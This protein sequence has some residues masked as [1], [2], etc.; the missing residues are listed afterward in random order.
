MLT[1]LLKYEFQATA[2]TFAGLYLALLAVAAFVGVL[3][4]FENMGKLSSILSAASLNV[5]GSTFGNNALTTGMLVYGCLVIAMGVLLF[6]TICQ[7]F[8]KN[9][10]G[11]EG[12]LMHTLPVKPAALVASKLLLAVF[13]LVCSIAVLLVSLLVLFAAAT[14]GMQGQL[15]SLSDLL[16]IR[17]NEY[18]L[19]MIPLL[20]MQ[21]IESV[22]CIY[23]AMM[24]GH[25]VVKG[26]VFVSI[27][28]FFL[29]EALQ[30]TVTTWLSE[31]FLVNWLQ[32]IATNGSFGQ[33][34]W[35]INV[36]MIAYAML[37][38]ALFF[39]AIAYLLRKRLNLV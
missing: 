3:L 11:S 22:L 31:L 33:Y 15:L 9:L 35:V 4:G 37:Y 20:L 39:A 10:L 7:R 25:Q 24:I 30:T 18:L 16:A 17:P 28:A 27:I 14:I 34:Y 8:H 1:K 5:N 26:S 23:L 29:L 2:R 19:T 6:V 21:Y 12:Y 32:S 38:S 13:W 36:I